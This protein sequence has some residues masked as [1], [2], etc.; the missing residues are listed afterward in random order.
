MTAGPRLQPPL[1]ASGEKICTRVEMS[2]T[3][4]PVALP[5]QK[6]NTGTEYISESGMKWVSGGTKRQ[7]EQTLAGPRPPRPPPAGSRP[8]SAAGPGLVQSVNNLL[9]S[10]ELN[11]ITSN[12]R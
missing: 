5:L 10:W 11:E 12:H 7:C 2:K 3:W 1:K 9:M 4:G 8:H 6:I